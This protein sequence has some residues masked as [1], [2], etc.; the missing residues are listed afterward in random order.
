MPVYYESRV[1]HLKLD[2]NTLR[3]IDAEYDVMAQN[4]DPYVIEKSKR[5]LGQMQSRGNAGIPLT[6]NAPYGYKEFPEAR[7]LIYAGLLDFSFHIL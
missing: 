6:T 1:I 2:E 4:A 7:G 3:L 5:E